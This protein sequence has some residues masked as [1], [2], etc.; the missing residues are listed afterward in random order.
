[1]SL[2]FV[3]IFSNSWMI[4]LPAIGRYIS[5][6]WLD[7]TQRGNLG[8]VHKVTATTKVAAIERYANCVW[9][10]IYKVKSPNALLEITF[11]H[12]NNNQTVQILVQANAQGSNNILTIKFLG[13][14]AA[15][16]EKIQFLCATHGYFSEPSF[17]P[18]VKNQIN[19][20]QIYFFICQEK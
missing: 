7:L 20:F 18:L 8:L 10:L 17:K 13:W 12:L 9:T 14:F 1:M 3:L 16:M 15:L 4:F 6:S 11:T 19:I 2:E 5:I